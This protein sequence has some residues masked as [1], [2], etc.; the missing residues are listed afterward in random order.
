VR[1]L[2]RATLVG[3]ASLVAVTALLAGTLPARVSGAEPC[4][5]SAF[6]MREGG[7]IVAAEWLERDG[8]TLRVHS[9][10]NRA[11]V[12]D[13]ELVLRPDESV[14]HAT[15]RPTVPGDP[16]LPVQQRDYDAGTLFWSD[17]MA[18][19]LELLLRQALRADASTVRL[20][21][22]SIADG[23]SRTALV[24]RTFA[25]A[26]RVRLGE[27]VYEATLDSQGCLSSALLPQYG[28]VFERAPDF[29]RDAYTA[30]P[31]YAAPP[32]GA[33]TAEEVRIPAPEGHVLAGTLTR[34]AKANGRLPA[35]VMI[36][37]ISKHERNHGRAPLHAF[38]DLADVLSRAGLVT[39][40]VDDRGVGASTGSW[41][42]STTLTEAQ[43]VH[44]E[45]AWL[46]AR[47]DVDPDRIALIGYSEGGLIAPIV[48]GE[49]RRVAAVVLLAGPGVPGTEL[50]YFQLEAAV[51]RDPTIGLLDRVPTMMRDLSGPL[52]PREST[53]L[54]LDPLD[55]APKV[56]APALIVQGG[57]DLHVPPVSAERL[58]AA[59][60][61]AGNR[62]VTVR[63]VPHVSHILSP[64]P[65][66]LATGWSHL[67]SYRPVEEILRTV[68]AWLTAHL[69]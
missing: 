34:P 28:I 64:D 27:R 24:E 46:R 30:W 35:V 65:E 25:N 22:A 6:V 4:P 1:P 8:S 40:R 3:H 50:Y 26:A 68:S 45:V 19:A 44:T 14:A 13:L 38:R 41:E 56:R 42:Q 37:G 66:G 62:D 10:S 33:Y 32:D 69:R 51:V 9:V 63:L 60:R 15:L 21:V 49:D 16:A 61:A 20:Q 36:S 7:A 47:R 39:L 48:A 53:F 52:S 11:L 55:Y 12:G 29:P 57:S 18:V 59:M 58:A 67:P 5:A 23:K 17:R 54:R 31:P 2:A 43:D